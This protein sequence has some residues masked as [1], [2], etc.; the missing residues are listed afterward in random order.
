MSK[1]VD[2]VIKPGAAETVEAILGTGRL[3]LSAVT[4][5]GAPAHHGRPVHDLRGRPRF[6]PRAAAKWPA[7]Q[8]LNPHFTLA[9]GTYYVTTTYGLAETRS[10]IAIGSGDTV[11]NAVV[12]DAGRLI[13]DVLLDGAPRHL[14]KTSPCVSTAAATTA[15]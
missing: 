10:R 3:E 5:Q 9:P 8:P 1:T 4:P 11:A 12:V 13:V 6:P 14:A 2:A 7:R 15:E